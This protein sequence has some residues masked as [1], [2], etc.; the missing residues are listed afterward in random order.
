MSKL[1]MTVA[2]DGTSFAFI[3]AGLDKTAYDLGSALAEALG[4][5]SAQERWLAGGGAFSKSAIAKQEPAAN[6]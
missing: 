6:E 4:D 3:E 2:S 5:P 1:A